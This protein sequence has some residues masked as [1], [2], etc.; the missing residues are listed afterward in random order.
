VVVVG[1]P[2]LV[3][4]QLLAQQVLVLVQEH[5]LQLVVEA[6]VLPQQE[7]EL[8]EQELEEQELQEQE[9]QEEQLQ[10]QAVLVQV[11]LMQV[12]LQQSLP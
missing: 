3:V 6:E 5:F 11:L 2:V 8:E 9:L 7:Q 4:E 12:D 10:V 1:Q